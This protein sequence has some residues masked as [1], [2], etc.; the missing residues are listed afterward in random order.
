[1]NPITF[2][3]DELLAH[4]EA[5]VPGRTDGSGYGLIDFATAYSLFD[6]LGVADLLPPK[7]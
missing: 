3:Y 7:S 6:A 1:M 5:G 4:R 2:T